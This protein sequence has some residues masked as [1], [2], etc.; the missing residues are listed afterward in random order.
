MIFTTDRDLLAHEPSL[1]RDVPL[2]GQQLARADDVAITGATLVSASSDFVAAGVEAGHVALVND[3]PIEITG[4]TNATTLTVSRIRA[5][6][7]DPVIPP[8]DGTGLVMIV[9]TYRPQIQAVHD[10]LMARLGIDP[11]DPGSIHT[12]ESILSV[13][14]MRR[15]E[16]LAT[17]ER[18]FAAGAAIS[19]ENRELWHK[20]AYFR[21]RFDDACREARV[22]LDTD[23]DGVADVIRHLGLIPLTRA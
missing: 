6:A 20:A 12:E 2:P 22:A 3:T 14:L 15:M 13:G 9:R 17:L 23:G 19:G 16:T 4:R 8:G 7:D 18:V 21:R 11:D 1:A 10:L 5:A